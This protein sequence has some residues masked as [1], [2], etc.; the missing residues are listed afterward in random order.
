MDISSFA[1]ATPSD[2]KLV[3]LEE[4]ASEAEIRSACNKAQIRTHPDK[5]DGS[6]AK[7]QAVKEACARLLPDRFGQAKKNGGT[8]GQDQQ[9]CT[10]FY[11][12][13]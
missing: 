3:G 8:W 6:S 5:K 11:S 2:F 1:Q 7:F 12:K 9:K 4:G 13:L 10:N